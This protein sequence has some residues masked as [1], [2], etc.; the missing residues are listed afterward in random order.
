MAADTAIRASIQKL[1]EGVQIIGFDWTY[2]YLNEAAER[3][4]RRHAVELVGR[5]MMDCYPGIDQT[6]VFAALKRVMQSRRAEQF[7]SE[8][9]YPDGS[10]GWFELLI[11]PVPDGVCVLSL[12][13][14]D[15]QR[16]Q[17]RLREAQTM[18]AAGRLGAASA[19]DYN[20]VLT[21]ILAFYDLGP[22]TEQEAADTPENIRSAGD[23]AERLATQLLSF[24]RKQ[25]PGREVMN[26][27][28]VVLDLY[29]MLARL[30]GEDIHLILDTAADL[31]HTRADPGQVEQI[32]MHLVVNARDA[33]PRGGTVRIATSNATLDAAFVNQHPGAVAG[34]YVALSIEDTGHGIPPGILEHVFEPFF[35]TKGPGMGTGLGL[36]TVHGIVSQSGGYIGVDTQAGVGTTITTYLPVIDAPLT[37]TGPRPEARTVSGSETVL[38]VE[39][40]EGE[41]DFLRRAIAPHGYTVLEAR[42][43]WDA[44]TIARSRTSP[45]DLLVTAVVLADMNGPE[46]AQHV[47]AMHPRMRVLYVSGFPEAS[48]IGPSIVSAR[49]SFLPRP[50][51]P[52]GTA[53]ER[54]RRARRRVPAV[55]AGATPAETRS[56]ICAANGAHVRHKC[57]CSGSANFD[58]IPVLPNNSGGIRNR[59]SG[60]PGHTCC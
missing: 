36:P 52:G 53:L 15:K 28:D 26:L 5:R 11:E 35:T 51:G 12:D 60:D 50:F 47:L 24:S 48:V 17:A 21:A 38:L 49:V 22:G 2:L 39:E 34:E 9:V 27:N 30:L 19:H 25:G 7:L 3:H 23:R 41:R 31:R 20:D 6:P 10:Q 44:L 1:L 29:A 55:G 13:L 56:D 58:G 54:A 45:I 33:T 40:D 37:E 43:V 18:E 16:A 4:A 57:P 32:L 59:G 42:D 14:G 8:F 46:L